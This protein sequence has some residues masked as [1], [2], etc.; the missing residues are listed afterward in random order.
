MLLCAAISCSWDAFPSSLHRAFLAVSAQSSG[1]ASVSHPVS[2]CHPPTHTP[3]HPPMHL[4]SPSTQSSTHVSIYLLY[5]LSSTHFPNYPASIALSAHP[6]SHLAHSSTTAS[7]YLPPICVS[8][9]LPI[10]SIHSFHPSIHPSVC[11]PIY[12]PTT[13]SCI[14][15][16]ICPVHSFISSIHLSI[17]IHS[18]TL[19]SLTH[20]S[21]HSSDPPPPTN[22][23]I[24][25]P[26]HPLNKHALTINGAGDT[27]QNVAS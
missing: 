6:F 15:S 20:L 3:T 13:H 10:L 17:I 9:H 4:T 24:Y 11:P 25:P 2:G 16:S 26:T 8:V 7:S 12:L 5:Y 21:I 22:P 27:N 1:S 23:F 18:S 14:N 19:F